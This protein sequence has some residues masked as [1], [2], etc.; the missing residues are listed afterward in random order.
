MKTKISVLLSVSLFLGLFAFAGLALSQENKP[1]LIFVEEYIVKPPMAAKFEAVVKQA[2]ELGF[3]IPFTTYSS[4]DCH[5]YLVYSPT[6]NYAGLDNLFKAFN[7]WMVKTGETKI[8]EWMKS[9]EGNFEYYKY[10]LIR[11]APEL[12]YVPQ[13][14][15]LKPGEENFF[16]WCFCYVEF[17]K[18][19]AMEGIFKE[20]VALSKNKGIA[21]GFTVFIGD[22]GTDM[23]F[24]IMAKGGKS[25]AD[26]FGEWDKMIIKWGEEKY[27]D[28]L[29]RVMGCLRRY[30]YKTGMVR[31]D[32]SYIPETKKPVK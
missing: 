15:R 29:T 13:K 5:Y 11:L 7:D 10:G 17:G 20:W 3:S 22:I 8:Q 9:Q 18:E 21:N 31:P 2:I 23:P 24:Y 30:E 16:H 27:T 6:E 28:L 32:L 19:K 4:D 1:Q 14:P 12:S 26:F 25:A